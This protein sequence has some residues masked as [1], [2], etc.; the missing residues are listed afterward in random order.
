[1]PTPA[2]QSAILGN[3]DRKSGL[4][5]SQKP[6][7]SG[8]RPPENARSL[9]LRKGSE[10]RAPKASF[11]AERHV[12]LTRLNNLRIVM[13]GITRPLNEQE[14]QLGPCPCLTSKP[15]TSP[16]S[17]FAPRWSRRVCL[18]DSFRF[19]GLS[20]PTERKKKVA[21]RKTRKEKNSSDSPH[22]R[23]CGKLQEGWSRN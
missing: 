18:P 8:V 16:T 1:M 14:R 3:G 21:K 10:Y 7:L 11:T 15:A 13:N 12:W 22:G 2:L 4:F 23:N 19:A 9:H 20:Y 5:W 6:A 17:S